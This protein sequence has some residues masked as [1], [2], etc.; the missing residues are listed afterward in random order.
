M[1]LLYSE[2]QGIRLQWR[3]TLEQQHPVQEARSKEDLL[4]QSAELKPDI[5][6]IHITSTSGI[7]PVQDIL[8]S[9]EEYPESRFIVFSDQPDDEEAIGL[10]RAGIHGYSRVDVTPDLLGKAVESV[11]SG[12]IWVG[13]KLMQQLVAELGKFTQTDPSVIQARVLALLTDRECEIA[14][15]V[16]NGENN[17]QI[18]SRCGITD[19]TV[20]AHL[21]SIFQKTGANDRLQLAILMT[22]QDIDK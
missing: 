22:G 6:L 12:E 20:K 16:A 4:K 15:G 9:R 19:R 18:A 11:S 10:L 21:G 8:Q 5:I 3:S 2:D 17:K 13:R 7:D 14:M 1:I